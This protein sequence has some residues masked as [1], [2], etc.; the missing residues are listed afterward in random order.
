MYTRGMALFLAVLAWTVQVAVAQTFEGE[1]KGWRV[2]TL[3]RDGQKLCYLSRS[4]TDKT[5]SA[6]R[7]G[8]PYLLVTYRD[9]QTSEVSVSAGYAYRP[10]STVAL[11]IDAKSKFALFTSEKTPE[12]A[13]AKDAIE[14]RRI[15]EAMSKGDK[16]SVAAQGQKKAASTDTYPLAGFPEA[17]QRMQELCQKTPDKGAT[18]RRGL[19]TDSGEKPGKASTNSKGKNPQAA[20]PKGKDLKAADPKGKDTKNR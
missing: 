6:K 2:Y 19:K 10:K 5:G 16:V 8:D 9:K 15:V 7:R 14:D 12:I 13:W 11:A 18:A 1:F 20:D 17:Y 3:S 4:P